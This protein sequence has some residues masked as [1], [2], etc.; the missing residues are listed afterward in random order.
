FEI[1]AGK[2]T[3]TYSFGTG[4]VVYNE[5]VVTNNHVTD[6]SEFTKDGGTS[7]RVVVDGSTKNL[8]PAQLVWASAELDL[9]V[10]KVPGLTRPTLTLSSTQTPLEYPDKASVVWAIGFPGIADRSITSETAFTHSTVTQGVV[11]KVVM[12]RAGQ[13]DKVRPVIQH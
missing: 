6:D 9:A 2:R 1:K 4:F 10:L 3:G 12:G 8:R 11:G 5:Y 7:E 13:R